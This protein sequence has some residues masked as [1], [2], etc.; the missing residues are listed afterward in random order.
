MNKNNLV[1]KVITWSVFALLVAGVVVAFC[2]NE[3]IFGTESIFYA[4]R[5][6]YRLIMPE[7]AEPWFVRVICL[8]NFRR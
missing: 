8:N 1:G 3:A 6:V 2:F 4:I 5:Y 7:L